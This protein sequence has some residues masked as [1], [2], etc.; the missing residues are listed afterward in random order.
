M[1]KK[2]ITA[3]AL[4]LLAGFATVLVG[5]ATA[6]PGDCNPAVQPCSCSGPADCPTGWICGAGGLCV[7]DGD[8]GVRD[9]TVDAS[10]DASTAA[11]AAVDAA[12]LLGFGEPC[13]D[14]TECSSNICLVVAT[15]GFCTML[16][17]GGTCPQDYGCF[18]VLDAV[19]QGVVSEVCVPTGNL[20]CTECSSNQECNLIGQ[21]LCLDYPDGSKYCARDCTTV[22]C[23]TGYTCEDVDVGGTSYRQCLPE[24]GAC[25]CD[26]STQGTLQSC[27]ITTPLGTC[28]GTMECLGASGWG[29]CEPAS[30]TDA[31]DGSFTD[32]NCDGIDGD[33]D[34]GIFV[35][36]GGAD[37]TTCGLDHTDPCLTINTGITRAVAETRS[38]V[39]VQTGAYDEV[40]E[41]A[42]G[43]NV[44]GGF[45][46]SWVRGDRGVSSHAVTILGGL[47]AQDGQYM[48]VRAHDLTTETKM[49]DLVIIGPNASGDVNGNG[50]SSY[51]VHA[52]NAWL[53]MERVTL[54]AGNGADGVA[55][56]TGQNAPNVNATS[57]MSGS[58]GGDSDQHATTCDSSNHGA[59][60]ARGTNS[61]SGTPS[62]NGGKGGNGGEMDTCCSGGFCAIVCD[63]TATPGD[64]GNNADHY[65]TNSYGSGGSGGSGGSSCGDPDNGWDGHI[66]NGSG[67]G[68]GGGGFIDSNYWYANGGGDGT[69]G[70]NGG[71][72]GGGG[73]SGGCDA[74][75]DSYGAGGGGGGAGG[76][77]AQSGGGGGGGGGGSFGIF[78]VASQVT[79]SDCTI[80]GGVAGHG[81]DGGTGGQ[82]QSGG[83]GAAGGTSDND[84]PP[85]GIGGD[86]G[87][88][89]HGGGGGGGAGGISYGAY[90][91]QSSVNQTCVFSGGAKGTK[92]QGGDSAPT[93]PVGERDGDGGS[94]GYDGVGPFSSGSCAVPTNCN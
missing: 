36:K 82:G 42:D 5:C 75:T 69:T 6:S 93:A 38:W 87:H 41:L 62:P 58:Q 20:L 44:A 13:N 71:G 26:A 48:A 33:Y 59:G 24:S 40:V 50:R 79:A 83:G 30:P 32:D 15:G 43:V 73:G 3:L 37:S 74:G 10:P 52:Q 65:A 45:D 77:A 63:C 25:N 78:A 8:A 55:G 23:P 66:Q 92:G 86:G 76:C 7:L 21:D 72:G 22:N 85:G 35:A 47:D 31:P 18:G 51:V 11:D 49:V 27:D 28:E 16:C 80:T 70:Y 90:G 61:C 4:G 9:G 91:Y 2:V 64:T 84:S 81:G 57:G 54:Q 89:G 56:S 19:E 34:D 12:P 14:K 67:G 39:Y 17:Q 60:G 94:D 1:C 88:G 29:T 46:T 53:T 68:G